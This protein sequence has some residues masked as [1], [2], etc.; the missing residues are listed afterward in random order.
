MTHDEMR[1]CR[2]ELIN[3]FLQSLYSY[4]DYVLDTIKPMI[5][6][7]EVERYGYELQAYKDYKS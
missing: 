3:K 2:R 7:Q 1:L 4:A 6:M 5:R